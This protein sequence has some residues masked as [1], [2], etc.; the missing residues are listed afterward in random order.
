[1]KESVEEKRKT[2]I[3]EK[4]MYK[5]AVQYYITSFTCQ[6]KR[7]LDYFSEASI[8]YSLIEFLKNRKG[9]V[10]SNISVMKVKTNY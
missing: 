10:R 9:L 7:R 2:F 5:S 8:P 6:K 4:K 3:C 1:M